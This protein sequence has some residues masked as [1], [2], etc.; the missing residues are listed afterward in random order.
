MGFVI[1]VT[2]IIPIV[3][4]K[5]R[6]AAPARRNLLDYTAFRDLPY[7]LF[8]IGIFFGFMGIFIIFFYIPLYAIEV[9]KIDADLASYLLPIINAASVFGRLI[10][11]LIADK[12]G[13]LNVEI[14]FAWI[15]A[16]LAFSWIAVHDTAGVI[17][18][19]VFYG[20][21]SGP[22]IS[23]AGPAIVTL[24]PNL[25]ILGTRMGMTFTFIGFGVLVGSPI[26]GAILR[27]REWAGLQAWCGVVLGISGVFILAARIAKVGTR[28][29][30]KA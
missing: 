6:V 7:M 11:N 22:F 4:M 8:N 2:S 17:V 3:T 25:S 12:T 26:A 23:I 15:A 16:I 29:G 1:L 18:F 21:F 20:F 30:A 27:D 13:P 10:P 14:L 9:C 5:Q 19:C 24:S 28:L